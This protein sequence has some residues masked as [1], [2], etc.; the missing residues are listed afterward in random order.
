VLFVSAFLKSASNSFQRLNEEYTVPVFSSTGLRVYS[1]TRPFNLKIADLQKGLI[2]VYNGVER[3]G[4]GT[5]FGFPVL[6]YGKET[7]FSASSTSSIARTDSSVRIRKEFIMDRIARNRFRNVHLENAQV[8]AFI[9]YLTELYQR[10]SNFRFLALK[11]FFVNI[12]VK[13]VFVKTASIGKLIV[14]YDLCSCVVNVKI[15]FSHLKKKHPEKIFVLNEQSA[16]F[17]RK[18]SDARHASFA[19]EQIGAWDMVDSE[20]A[21]ITDMQGQVG[22]RLWSVNGSVLRRGREVM[23]GHMDWVGL[24]YEVEPRNQVFE[25]KIEILGGSS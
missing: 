5:G 16:N 11:E 12:G 23:N 6:T 4:E 20:W 19:D 9:K 13:S 17:F 22:F 24:D 7:F 25:Y 14:T 1:D 2:L 3:V 15:D 10:S 21:S 18:Y 8:R